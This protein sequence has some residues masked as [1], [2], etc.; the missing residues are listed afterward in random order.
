M[1][2]DKLTLLWCA[3]SFLAKVPTEQ[4][5]ERINSWISLLGSHVPLLAGTEGIMDMMSEFMPHPFM[6]NDIFCPEVQIKLKTI[7][8][9][10]HFYEETVYYGSFLK[11]HDPKGLLLTALERIGASPSSHI[12]LA[13]SFP[14]YSKEVRN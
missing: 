10:L 2:Q 11:V 3:I 5:T 7:L 6:R 9:L 13:Q 12:R 8:W 14:G 1:L 4:W